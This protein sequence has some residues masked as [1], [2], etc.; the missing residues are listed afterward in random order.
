LL[1]SAKSEFLSALTAG[2]GFVLQGHDCTSFDLVIASF[3]VQSLGRKT[4]C[5][6]DVV[7]GTGFLEWLAYN[8]EPSFEITLNQVDS[9]FHYTPRQL[10]GQVYG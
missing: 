5:L 2:Q 8:R 4:V 9:A 10:S 7:S 1:T 6:V 3:S